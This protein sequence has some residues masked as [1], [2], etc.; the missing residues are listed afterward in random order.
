MQMEAMLGQS[1]TPRYTYLRPQYDNTQWV[2]RSGGALVQAVDSDDS[3]GFLWTHN[4][5]L[6]S[7]WRSFRYVVAG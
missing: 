5:L 7:K 6:T 2:H 1:G 4:Y 3:P